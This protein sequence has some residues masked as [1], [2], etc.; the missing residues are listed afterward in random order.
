M[1]IKHLEDLP[2]EDFLTIVQGFNENSANLEVSMKFDGSANLGF[3]LDNSGRLFFARFAKGQIQR[4]KSPDDWPK[5]P[6][7]NSI[8]AAVAALLTQ[9]DLLEDVLSPGDYIN[10]EILFEK[11]PNSI[12][13]GRNYIIF[14]DKKYDFL[15]DKLPAMKTEVELVFLNK[16]GYFDVTFLPHGKEVINFRKFPI[17]IR[18]DIRNLATYLWETNEHFPEVNNISMLKIRAIGRESEKIKAEKIRLNEILDVQKKG[19]KDKLVVQFLSKLPASDIAPEAEFDDEGNNIGGSFPEG[20]VIVDEK[21]GITCKLVSIFP[22][23][24]KFFWQYREAAVDGT[25]SK[26]NWT[27]GIFAN[28]KT[29]VAEK[30]F[31]APVLKTPGAK[32]YIDRRYPNTEDLDVRLAKFIQDSEINLKRIKKPFIVY[33]NKALKELEALKKKFEEEIDNTVLFVDEPGYRREFKYDKIHIRKTLE[34]FQDVERILNELKQAASKVPSKS[35]IAKAVKILKIFLYYKDTNLIKDGFISSM[36]NMLVEGFTTKKSVGIIL[37]RFTPTHNGHAKLFKRALAE[38]DIVYIFVGGKKMDDKNFLNINDRITI[39]RRWFEKV[40]GFRNKKVYIK[41]LN[42]GFIPDLVSEYVNVDEVSHVNVYAGSDRVKT[43]Q[44]QLLNYW[45]YDD[46][47]H[48]I[49][50]V[51]R[52]EHD[53]SSTR[54]RHYLDTNDYGN[55]VRNTDEVSHVFENGGKEYYLF[56]HQQYSQNVKENKVGKE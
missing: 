39:I 22:K 25:G 7:Y 28:F 27:P 20:V 38:N 23:V 34:G 1:G 46:I 3:G 32:R 6:M 19:I 47:T 24:N 11:I 4:K 15:V 44:R 16:R 36:K 10:C 55:F 48:S 37:G 41:R 49:I 52:T 21:N 33:V 2:I 50:E 17:E 29:N 9:K 26:G 14:H 54:L 53:A 13:Y 12:E 35:N 43:Y 51:N 45:E 31:L 30:I 40:K 18:Q 5:T 8:R 56:C 42:T